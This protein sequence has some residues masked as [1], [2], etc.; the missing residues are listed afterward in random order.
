[1]QYNMQGLL[2]AAPAPWLESSITPP[3]AR[4]P[5]VSL[6]WCSRKNGLMEKQGKGGK[7]TENWGLVSSFFSFFTVLLP[8]F[9]GHW[10]HVGPIVE[11]SHGHRHAFRIPRPCRTAVGQF[12]KSGLGE[13][14]QRAV[15]KWSIRFKQLAVEMRRFG[16]V[17]GIGTSLD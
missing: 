2:S 7:R 13:A 12:Y 17:E 9:S 3:A 6:W 4:Q 1:M 15:R 10:L 11:P 16:L 8:F 5:V 14:A